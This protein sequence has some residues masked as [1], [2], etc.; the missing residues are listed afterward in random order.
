MYLLST[1]F[2]QCNANFLRAGMFSLLFTA[3]SP[4]SR[5]WI[6]I[7]EWI[8][9]KKFRG[10]MATE[11]FNNHSTAYPGP[12]ALSI[13]LTHYDQLCSQPRD[14]WA[15]PGKM[16]PN[17]KKGRLFLLSVFRNKEALR[18]FVRKQSHGRWILCS[19]TRRQPLY[20][21][22]QG[23]AGQW[24]HGEELLSAVLLPQGTA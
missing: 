1:V 16:T 24:W 17:R 14:G 11:L 22:S 9:R 10:R 8:N 4:H 5:C 19:E 23:R 6:S 12:R 18:G 13:F 3:V 7:L 15:H 2:L 20:L 21:A